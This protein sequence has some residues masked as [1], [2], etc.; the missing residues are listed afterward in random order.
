[1]NF[2]NMN[3]KQNFNFQHIQNVIKIY[4]KN[5]IFFH[6]KENNLSRI[7]KKMLLNKV[8][9]MFI[10]NKDNTFTISDVYKNKHYHYKNENILI[11]EI[12]N[13]KNI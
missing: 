8:R 2:I 3:Q 9:Y 6:Y 10:Y 5:S 7:K 12:K 1:M 11:D 4:Y 13:K